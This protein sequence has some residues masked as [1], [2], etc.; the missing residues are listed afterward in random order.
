MKPTLLSFT[1]LLIYLGL[2]LSPLGISTQL[3]LPNRPWM[4]QISS[5]LGM[6]AFNIILL[7]FLSTG[8]I[9]IISKL[10]GIDWVLQVHQ[11]FARTAVLLLVVHPF[12]YSLPGRPAYSPG[13][14]NESYLGLSSNPFISG[15]VG[16]IILGMMGGLAITRN[17][18]ESKYETWR[19]THAIMAI[20]V[21]LLGFHHTI[22]AGRFAQEPSMHLYWQ[23]ALGLA[24]LSIAWVYLV[25]PMIQSMNAYQVVSI[26]EKS[27]HIWELVIQHGRN[28][29]ASYKAGQFAWLKIGGA[30]PL[31]ENPFSIASCSN[32]QSSQM[33]FLIKDVGDFT[34]QVTELKVGDKIYVDAPYG[35]FGH[36]I[37]SSQPNE[38]V[39]IAGGVGIAPIASLLGKMAE[40]EQSRFTDKKIIL[41]YGNRITEQIIDI[42]QMVNLNSLKQF[43]LIHVITE[44]DASWK[45]L[46]GVLDKTSLEKILKSSDININTAQYFVCGPAVMIDS[47]ENALAELGVSLNQIDSEKFQ[48]DFSQKNARNRLSLASWLAATGALIA[49]A[50]YWVNR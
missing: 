23:V 26:K 31:Y 24:M 47:V 10:L 37:F 45:G 27:H 25:R 1:S 50:I 48:Y 13:P 2:V 9:K 28:K 43:E 15:L 3:D 40:N 33:K 42:H 34:H 30:A 35:N 49:S 36:D 16:L 5:N 12:M 32:G 20:A 41:I 22:H 29:I 18:S 39:L 4:D 19:A 14:A 38:I 11:L 44:P 17:K 7:E 46:I 21:A 6:L 8:R